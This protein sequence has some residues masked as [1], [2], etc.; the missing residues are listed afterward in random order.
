MMKAKSLKAMANKFNWA[1][2]FLYEVEHIGQLGYG[3]S[4]LLLSKYGKEKR[5]NS[6][7]AEKYFKAFPKLLDINDPIYT[8]I[9]EYGS[10]CY[11]IRTFERFL[12]YFGLIHIEKQGDKFE[13]KTYIRKAELFDK[14]IKI[15]AHNK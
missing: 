14:L 13:R 7:Y 12:D 6:F 15:R 8:T 5:L 1:F 9:E 11:S 4:L 10:N 3:F 2:F